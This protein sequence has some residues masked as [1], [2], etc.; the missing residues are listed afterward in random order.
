MYHAGATILGVGEE[1]MVASIYEGGRVLLT[2]IIL[3]PIARQG[4]FCLVSRRGQ[5]RKTIIEKFELDEGL[6]PYHPP[7]PRQGG[8]GKGGLVNLSSGPAQRLSQTANNNNTTTTT[9][10]T[11]TSTT[12]TTTTTT[13][14]IIILL[15]LIIMIMMIR[16]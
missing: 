13:T 6:Q 14:I 8:V 16:S 3:P 2:E 12:T 9:T 4:A 10:T 7:L 1:I 11:T 5:A 15:L